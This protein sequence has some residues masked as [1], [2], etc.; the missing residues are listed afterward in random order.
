MPEFKNAMEV[1]KLLDKSN[2]RK[3]NETTCLAFASKVFL[4]QKPLDL[5][6][7]L[8][9]SVVEEYRDRAPKA[10]PGENELNRVM[11]ELKTRLADCD[12][13]DAARR[14]GGAY[15][16]GWLTLRI[17]GKPFAI[18]NQGMFRTDLHINPWIVIPV[19]TYVLECHGDPITG[20]WSPFRELDRG[21]E[22]NALFVQ[23]G[24]TPLKKLADTYPGLF[25]DLVDMFSG[26]TLDRQYESDISLVLYPLPMLPMLICYWRP[27]DGMASDLNLFFDRS[28]D[29][30]GGSP[31]IF[32]L[33][34]G[35]V[36]MFE[37]FALT[38]GVKGD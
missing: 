4:G 23:R 19:L 29:Q 25:E 26:K 35:L 33:T 11:R 13:E 5:C 1:F 20:H 7:V 12:L 18:N 22:K 32:S 27:E 15:D 38:H 30:N 28:A 36:Q 10:L 2:C 3:C 37:K 21:R 9:A 24:E 34:T 14:T 31:T 17:L 16:G 8:E 6:P